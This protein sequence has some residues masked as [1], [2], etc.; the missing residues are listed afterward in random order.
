M[1]LAVSAMLLSFSGIFGYNNCEHLS[2]RSQKVLRQ[3]AIGLDM[4][5]GLPRRNYKGGT[6]R[7]NHCNTHQ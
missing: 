5:H 7:N 6:I 2:T 4:Q 1:V 3:L